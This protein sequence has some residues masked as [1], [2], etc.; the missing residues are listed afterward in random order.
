[1]KTRL[2]GRWALAA[3]LALVWA[4]AAIGQAVESGVPAP[5]T[6]QKRTPWDSEILA[7]FSKMPV[8]DDG[9]VKPLDTFAQFRLLRFNGKRECVTPWKETLSPIAWLL[10]SLF[11][12]EL[13]EQYKM[14]VVPS[15]DALDAAGIKHE[16]KNKRDR[17]SY[18][19]LFTGRQALMTKAQELGHK[20]EKDRTTTEQ[21]IVSLA[22]SMRDFEMI[23]HYLDFARTPLSIP[24][25]PGMA[26]LF[27]NPAEVRYADVLSKAGVIRGA[28]ATLQAGGADVD[29]ATK[30][31]ELENIR[32]LLAQLDKLGGMASEL[33]LFPPSVTVK[34]QPAWSAPAD[35]IEKAFTGEVAPE[36]QIALLGSLE[37]LVK[38]RD[39]RIAF[40]GTLT[41]MNQDVVALASARGEYGKIPLEVFLYKSQFLYWS[42]CVFVLGFVLVAS[43]WLA[44]RS[45]ILGNIPW[46]AAVPGLALLTTVIV[47]RCIIRGRPPVTTL[48]ETILFITA[49]AVF[50]ALV[51]EYMNRQRIALALSTLLGSLGLFLAYKFELQQGTDTMPN[52]VAVLDTNFWLATH[53]TT[54]TIG[55]SAG[56][57]AAAVAHVYVIGQLIGF[58]KSDK[59][60]YKS[61]T[62]MVYGVVCFGLVFSTVGTVLGGIWANYS[63]GRFWGWDPKENGALMIV[64][65]ELAV[66]HG[67]MGG[68]IR[69]FGM[70]MTAIFGG[71]I[72]AFSW[73]GVNLLGVGLHAYGFTSGIFSA[74][75]VFYIIETIVLFLGAGLWIGRRGSSD[76]PASATKGKHLPAS[77]DSKAARAR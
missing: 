49:T 39:D 6:V 60:F 42:L 77:A 22:M 65:W 11:Y 21:Q 43:S 16:G 62:R 1:M 27:P 37:N 36:K 51:I 46:L 41:G 52:L 44:P 66:L 54:V 75:L 38:Q 71:M 53:V 70:N 20:E 10:D 59:A 24:S 68:Y 57:L 25:S 18:V 73:F 34:E 15:W 19:E 55:Y 72:V 12:P 50:V 13:A 4:G 8:Q 64:L 28:M 74:L 32:S 9:R 26:N 30:K 67:R 29:E 14:F 56:L 40:R 23:T 63:W 7:A 69:D 2:F 35:L 45:R 3:G 47:L 33:A 31:K 58:K 61:L 17:Y 48:Y 76:T 5:P